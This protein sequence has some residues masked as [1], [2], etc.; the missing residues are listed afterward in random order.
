MAKV[1]LHPI[2]LPAEEAV[3][4]RAYSENRERMEQ[5]SGVLLNRREEVGVA[6]GTDRDVLVSLDGG[7]AA[8]RIDHDDLAAAFLD[9]FKA[10]WEVGRCAE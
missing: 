3:S 2:G 7:L 10:P 9:P 5:L 1:I 8:P 6:T 4:E